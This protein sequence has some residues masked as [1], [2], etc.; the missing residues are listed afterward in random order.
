MTAATPPTVAPDLIRGPASTPAVMI[1]DEHYEMPLHGWTCFHCGET[2][3]TPGAARQHFGFTPQSDP[4]CRI[5]LGAER[6]L[7]RAYRALEQENERLQLQLHAESAEGMQAFRG[8]QSR[9]Q[10]ITRHAE[11]LGY[12]RGFADGQK[13][14]AT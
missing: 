3:H 4:A 2:F 13:E 11:E 5:K 14:K 12:E 10:Q 7:L 8:L 6:S 1:D 9:V